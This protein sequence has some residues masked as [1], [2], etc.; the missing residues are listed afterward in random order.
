MKGIATLTDK[1]YL[2]EATVPFIRYRKYLFD[3]AFIKRQTDLKNSDNYKNYVMHFD[4]EN[5]F[6]EMDVS[7]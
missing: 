5:G 7:N 2:L 3:K 4:Y 6:S 1:E